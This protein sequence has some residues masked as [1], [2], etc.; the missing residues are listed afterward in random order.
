MCRSSCAPPPRVAVPSEGGGA[1]PRLRGVGGSALLRPSNRGGSRGG[2]GGWAAP[3]PPPPRPHGCRPATLCLQRAPPGYTRAVGVA[4]RPWASGAA[5]SAANGSLRRGGGR[6]GGSD[7]LALV[8][9]PCL[10]QAG[11]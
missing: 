2:G 9:A 4:G 7:L 1:S 11:L 8:R 3:P 6:E 10:S 5:R